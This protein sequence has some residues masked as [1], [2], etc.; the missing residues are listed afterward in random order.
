MIQSTANGCGV[1][2]GG[3]TWDFG[4]I[5]IEVPSTASSDDQSLLAKQLNE[6]FENVKSDDPDVVDCLVKHSLE[7]RTPG[8]Q[9]LIVTQQQ[10]DAY[11]GEKV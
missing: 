10:F 4:K 9:N 6:V 3:V 2:I 5:T 1:D 7:I 11:K 8:S